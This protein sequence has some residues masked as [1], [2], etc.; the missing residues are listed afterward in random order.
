MQLVLLA[1]CAPPP[2]TANDRAP[3]PTARP[4]DEA[5]PR[6]LTRAALDEAI[7]LG[8]SFLLHNQRPEGNFAYQYDWR[9]QRDDDD[10]S[11][12]RQAGALWGVAL[13]H[14]RS[15]TPQLRAALDRGLAFFDRHTEVVG[16][17]AHVNYP[18]FPVGRLGTVCLLA[19][20]YL[21]RR[22][23]VDDAEADVRLTQLLTFIKRARRAGGGFHD[24]YTV[25]GRSFGSRS[26]YF[27]G[28]ALL[29]LTRASREL[30]PTLGPLALDEADR[31]YQRHVTEALRRDADSNE[32]KG[33]YQWCSMALSALA[34]DHPRM[35]DRLLD[36]AVW[37]VDV[38]RTLSRQR[39]TGYAYEGLVMAF[40]EAERRGDAGMVRKLSCVIEQG[41]T[42]LMSWQVGFSGANATIASAG[43]VEDPRALGGVQNHATEPDLR[44][45]V[46]QHQMHALLL[47]REQ[48]LSP[49]H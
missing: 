14:R 12:V 40:A 34:P 35:G 44:I 2:I 43:P 16:D 7:D 23:V 45:D 6:R 46:T 18:D 42:K 30:D 47:A 37:M 17:R 1:G 22:Q 21:D 29:V 26:P 27:D 24:S 41:L 31:S 28:E 8:T 19:L 5:C 10:D 9:A 13:L 3:I 20:A 25:S 32:T 39:N 4:V 48:Y 15:P 36:L 11:P 33:Y 49:S 38:H